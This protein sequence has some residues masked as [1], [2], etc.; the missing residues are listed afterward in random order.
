MNTQDSCGIKLARLGSAGLAVAV[1]ALLRPPVA[2]AGE[3]TEDVASLA[4]PAS[5]E[6][7]SAR[8]AAMQA[9]YVGIA[10]GAE[11]LRWN[12][13][14]LGN[15]TLAEAGAH[16]VSG[17][18]GA[19]G[20]SVVIGVPLGRIGGLA[21]SGDYADAGSFE[22]RDSVG[23]VTGHHAASTGGIG[24]GYGLALPMDLAVGAAVKGS[25]QA[26]AGT[27]YTSF[28]ADL[29]ALWTGM[30]PLAVGVALDNLGTS[31]SASTLAWGIR[32]G[33]SYAREFGPLQQVLAAAAAEVQPGGLHRVSV[34]AEDTFFRRLSVRIGYRLNLADQQLDGLTGMTAGLGV[35][36]GGVTLDYAWLPAGDLGTLQRVSL[37][38][39]TGVKTRT[40]PGEEGGAQ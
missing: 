14:G 29:G 39:R 28:A 18:G 5:Q 33:A 4:M 6:R 32:A 37:T 16:H 11:A 26:L 35:A 24:I 23:N 21:A 22:T 13:A 7:G 25:R 40:G 12:P 36:A 9:T 10:Q 17:L 2:R 8:A 31:G 30:A 27:S 38:Y 15:L 3:T 20:E 34:G 19:I 1:F